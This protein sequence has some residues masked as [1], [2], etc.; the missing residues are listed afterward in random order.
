[1]AQ[2]VVNQE[3]LLPAPSALLELFTLDTRYV[4]SQGQLFYFHAG[5]NGLLREVI[6][7][8]ITYTPFPIEMTEFEIAGNGKLARPKVK[9]SNVNGFMSQYLLTQN[10]LLGARLARTRVYARFLDAANWPNNVN[11]YGTPD[12]TAAYEPEV[13]YVNRK[14]TENAQYVEFECVTPFEIDGVKLPR[15]PMLATVCP[16]KYRDPT[17]CGYTGAPISDR[18]GKVFGPGGYGFNALA[19]KGTWSDS[20]NYQTGDWV[21]IISQADLSYG[22]T[23]VYVTTV[24]NTSGAVNNPQFN[25]TNWIADGCPHNLLGCKAHFPTGQLPFG[26]YP[27]LARAPFSN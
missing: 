18:F 26:G 21:T 15:R 4:T 7:N 2:Q 6:Y 9:C 1:M 20:T 11:P 24:P 3:S 12:P 23:L 25:Q 14:V 10:N 22:D 13:Y 19:N 16:F 8:G 17:T 5:V 27:A